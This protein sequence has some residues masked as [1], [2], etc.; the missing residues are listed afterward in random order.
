MYSYSKREWSF[1][2]KNK[3]VHVWVMACLAE[4]AQIVD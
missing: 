4:S 3:G 2:A 1:E